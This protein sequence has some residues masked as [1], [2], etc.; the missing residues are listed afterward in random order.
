[1]EAE[2]VRVDLQIDIP[3]L[4]IMVHQ[5]L[6]AVLVALQALQGV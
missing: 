4:E 2:E 6:L 3:A 1:M 5:Y